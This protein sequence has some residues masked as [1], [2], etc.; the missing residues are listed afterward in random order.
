MGLR[1]VIPLF[2]LSALLVAGEVDKKEHREATKRIAKQLASKESE[3]VFAGLLE[4]ARNH[5]PSLA[6]PLVKL[7]KHKNP[8][9]RA[10]AIE[11]LGRRQE[12]ASQKKAASALAAR[13]KPLSEKE[14]DREE[15]LKAIQA[16]HDLAQPVSIKALLDTRADEDRDIV[17][18][19]AMAVANVPSKEAIERLIQFGYKGRKSRSRNVASA[20]LRY[21]TQQ[22]VKGGIE[23]WRKWWSDNKKTFDVVD[24]A[25]KR[26]EKRAAEQAKK[27]KRE[28]RKKN[29]NKRKKKKKE[30]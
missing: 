17:S 18:A 13:L 6:A 3:E 25:A 21:A 14:S 19:R 7:L 8:S 26:D 23:Q 5:D 9:I 28:E 15:L 30:D 27:A 2:A 10:G 11:A 22:P 16:L 29:K 4:A 20:A 24:A 12:L 1:T